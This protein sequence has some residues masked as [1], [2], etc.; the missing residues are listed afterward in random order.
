MSAQHAGWFAEQIAQTSKRYDIFEATLRRLRASDANIECFDVFER[1]LVGSCHRHHL[2]SNART[3]VGCDRHNAMQLEEFL[4]DFMGSA[5]R[6]NDVLESFFG[7]V[8]FGR[9]FD[10]ALDGD[11]DL[12]GY[13]LAFSSARSS[14]SPRAVVY[15]L[16]QSACTSTAAWTRRRRQRDAALG[17]VFEHA[18]DLRPGG[19]SLT[20]HAQFYLS[21][22]VD[23]GASPAVLPRRV[24]CVDLAP[25]A[26]PAAPIAID[27]KH[28]KKRLRALRRRRA[29]ACLQHHARV[30][31][32]RALARRVDASIRIQRIARG[33]LVRRA[34]GRVRFRTLAIAF[35]TKS[36]RRETAA[37]T[38]QRLAARRRA[39]VMRDAHLATALSR[40]QGV[41]QASIAQAIAMNEVK[42]ETTRVGRRLVEIQRVY[43]ATARVMLSHDGV[44]MQFLVPATSSMFRARDEPD[45]IARLLVMTDDQA[46]AFFAPQTGP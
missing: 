18:A 10:F 11:G 35:A 46:A 41:S 27:R 8:S 24:C 38:I 21:T 44:T 37:L 39:H 40:A 31:C 5:T 28:V 42:T 16:V 23:G 22:V 12:I 2:A 20:D 45:L 26:P 25:E 29:I 33:L 1:A 9:A 15:C 4:F 7:G 34:R 32:D 14:G 13:A 3:V 30:L 19:V 17:A 6:R 36:R 43:S